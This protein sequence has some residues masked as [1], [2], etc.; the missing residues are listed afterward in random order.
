M[1]VKW[2]VLSTAGIATKVSRAIDL[3]PNAELLAV[4][5]RS[6]ERA[7]TWARKHG[8]ARAYGSYEALLSDP[9]IDAVYI[10]LPPT[11]HSE[12][13]I[14]AAKAGKH[15]LSEK[16]LTVDVEEAVAMEV[17]CRENKVQ[18]MDGVMWVHHDWTEEVK[19][20]QGAGGLGELRHV[21]ASF[22]FNW[23]STIPVDNIRAQKA[24]GGGALGDLG[25][26]CVR[27]ILWAFGEM[28]DAVFAKGR[29]ANGVDTEMT[30]MLFFS[31]NRTATFNC[32]FTMGA[33][34]ALELGGSDSALWVDGFV[35][36][37]SE[38]E[39][40]FYTGKKIG[41]REKHRLGPCVQEARMIE[42]FSGIVESGIL[43]PKLSED[44]VNTTRIC[45]ALAQSAESQ[46]VVELRTP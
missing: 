16:P 26:Y 3:A 29:Y 11:M 4:A 13:A 22:S 30:G 8:A 31:D 40:F 1:G 17:A 6:A 44:A 45:C 35:V 41:V 25:Y 12:W 20:L 28:P 46:K 39:S 9:D 2:G 7:E 33:R 10:P 15:V 37:P 5:S 38:D 19:K 21:S 36:P 42:H 34:A 23:G 27:G 32:G 18:L 24:L 14:K 43:D